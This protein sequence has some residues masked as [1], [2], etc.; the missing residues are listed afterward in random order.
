LFT[1]GFFHI[2]E[3]VM[4]LSLKHLV[5]AA[6]IATASLGA[7][8]CNQT[9]RA[10]R[11]AII[12]YHQGDY[13]NAAAELKPATT[14]RDEN[15]V[16][17]NCRYGSCALAA[18]QLGNAETAFMAAYE[19]INGVN[20]NNGGRTMGAALVFEGVKVWK[21]EPFERAMAHYYLGLIFLIKHDYENARAAFQN[22]IFKLYEYADK[23]T[24]QQQQATQSNFAL[25]YYGLGL[26]YLRLG[27]QDLAQQ[28]FQQ[29]LRIDPSLATVIN[30]TAQPATN[31]LIFV[32][33]GWGPQRAGKG[34]YN[35]ESAFY[36]T[37][38]EAGPVPP[39][40][41]FVDGRPVTSPGAP[42][43]YK[44][45]DTLAM[46]QEQRWQDIDT[47]RKTKAVVGTGAMAA[48]T[49][50]AAYGAHKHDEGMMW[51]GVGIAALGGLV[52]ASSQAD[53]R[54]WEMLPRTVYVVPLA[55][56]PGEHDIL[57]AAGPSRSAP[58][59]VSIP[60]P[61]ST[62]AGAPGQSGA[63]DTVLYFRIR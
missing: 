9:P 62:V 44:M 49:G 40:T 31:T 27:R 1:L 59:H 23:D 33:A 50:V 25:G 36:P 46:A 48:G 2:S 12:L 35:E 58:I 45:V 11:N 26:T 15:F 14:K 21:G 13:A 8:G 17:D 60:L 10:A 54:Y 34:W 30:Q 22:S 56:P 6:G 28:N 37:P 41:T 16:L 19:V 61:N 55:L 7:V 24:L 57:V 52:T 63:R 20:T 51:T 39:L 5:V 38:A 47:I 53:L 43:Q 4:R 3:I 18:G 42:A 32:D 29:A